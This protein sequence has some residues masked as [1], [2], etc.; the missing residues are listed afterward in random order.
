MWTR[1]GLI[2]MLV[3]VYVLTVASALAAE[4]FSVGQRVELRAF[5]EAGVPLYRDPHSYLL[6]RAPDDSSAVIH[7]MSENQRWLNVELE[8]DGRV[9]W[10]VSRYVKRNLPFWPEGEM[11]IGPSSPTEAE[12]KVWTSAETCEQVVNAGQ[13][14]APQ[15]P[16]VLRFATWN[17]R[18]FSKEGDEHSTGLDG[19]VQPTDLR[20]LACVLTWMNVDLVVFQGLHAT[21]AARDAWEMITDGLHAY[22]GDIWLLS[23]QVCGGEES[24]QIGFLR[25]ISRVSLTH[26]Q[27]LWQL[28][29]R[30]ESKPSRFCPDS[31]RPGWYAFLKGVRR[32]GVDLHLI[33]LH[34]EE[35]QEPQAREWRQTAL[36]RLGEAV[37]PFLE[38]DDDVVVAGTFNIIAED[39]GKTEPEKLESVRRLVQEEQPGFTLVDMKP[40]CT[41]YVDGKAMQLDH[42]LV[43]KGMAEA[44]QVEAR[45][46]GICALH[47]CQ[48]I[49]TAPAAYRFLS[50]HCP[51]V[52][53]IANHDQDSAQAAVK[54]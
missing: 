24:Q 3:L 9:G 38:Q 34:L 51:V 16:D 37:E 44:P 39:G 12:W 32:E 28:N 49:E 23:S 42:F 7:A 22:T 29:G 27:D 15:H 13:R 30:A 6:G 11:V 40:A 36:T 10:I 25:N 52:Y 17:L 43:A 48:N 2:L 31:G 4:K 1:R 21:P 47:G 5:R 19:D 50:A 41:A 46:T 35:G 26:M 54:P 53:A 8:A 33:G 45:V 18:S 20:W 14:M